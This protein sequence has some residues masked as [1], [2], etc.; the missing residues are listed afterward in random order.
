MRALMLTAQQRRPQAFLLAAF[1]GERK[2]IIVI[3]ESAQR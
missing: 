1:M 2:Q 3:I